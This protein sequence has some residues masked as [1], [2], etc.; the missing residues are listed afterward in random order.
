MP[1]RG[2]EFEH[3]QPVAEQIDIV[4][5]LRAL[6]AAIND[7]RGERIDVVLSADRDIFWQQY[8]PD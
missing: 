2:A 5:G 8:H 7:T 6:V 1:R 3:L 4:D